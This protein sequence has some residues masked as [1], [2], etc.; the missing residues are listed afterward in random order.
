[1]QPCA[2]FSIMHTHADGCI[3][4]TQRTCNNWYL[5]WVRSPFY[6]FTFKPLLLYSI[7]YSQRQLGSKLPNDTGS[8]QSLYNLYACLYLGVHSQ[9]PEWEQFRKVISW[10]VSFSCWLTLH[11]INLIGQLCATSFKYFSPAHKCFLNCDV[12][13]PHC[14]IL[15]MRTEFQYYFYLL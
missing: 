12:S 7:L 2:H 6:L 5:K 9:L 13:A 11:C 14:E 4:R 3:Q 1:M 15:W 8:L 10:N